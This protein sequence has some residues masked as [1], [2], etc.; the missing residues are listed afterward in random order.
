[1]SWQPPTESTTRR[2]YGAA[3]QRKRKQYADAIDRGE[4]VLCHFCNQP[5]VI[6]NG[7]HPAGLHLD[8]GIDRE[9]YRGP[10]HNACNVRDGA[11]RG[12]AKQDP[13]R[14]LVL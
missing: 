7:R 5:I 11:V 13:P 6:S 1:M 14:R 3:H 4:M 8:H 2:G 12:R 9:T 10:S